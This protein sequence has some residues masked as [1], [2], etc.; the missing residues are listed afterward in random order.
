MFTITGK[1]AGIVWDAE[2]NKPLIKFVDGKAETA[3]VAVAERLRALGYTV[4]GCTSPALLEMT[5]AEL[6]AYASENNIDLG[7]AT[8]KKEIITKIQEAK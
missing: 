7:E 6:N 8:K 2:H 4:E 1:K 3:D 5:V